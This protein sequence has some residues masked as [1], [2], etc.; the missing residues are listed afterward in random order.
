[1]DDDIE[2]IETFR[3]N[4][5]RLY[6]KSSLMRSFA[7]AT[8]MGI[9]AFLTQQ[10]VHYLLWGPSA[11]SPGQIG[12]AAAGTLIGLC[13]FGFGLYAIKKA[14]GKSIEAHVP[15]RRLV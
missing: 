5:D 2:E 13:L 8:M 15:E 10:S 12:L 3:L 4:V 14:E 1:M 11:L 9:G 7:R 6:L